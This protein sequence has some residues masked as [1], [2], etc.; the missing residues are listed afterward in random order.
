LIKIENK[1]AKN[2][3]IPF[4]KPSSLLDMSH[5]F[6]VE[7]TTAAK[8]RLRTCCAAKTCWSSKRSCRAATAQRWSRRRRKWGLDASVVQ[9]M[10]GYRVDTVDIQTEVEKSM[11]THGVPMKLIKWL[12]FHIYFILYP[13][14]L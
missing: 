1:N 6:Y 13:I 14:G 4:L 12:I 5:V 9:T 10:V 11:T 7:D 8:P 2:P 3:P